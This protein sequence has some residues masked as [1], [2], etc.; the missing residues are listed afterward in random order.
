MVHRH[1]ITISILDTIVFSSFFSCIFTCFI[2][3]LFSGHRFEPM[4]LCV[5]QFFTLRT[6]ERVFLHNR[7]SLSQTWEM[8]FCLEG[9]DVIYW[10][11]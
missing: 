6:P 8:C 7:G 5:C 4:T 9:D 3:G 2:S 11:I 1:I 10:L